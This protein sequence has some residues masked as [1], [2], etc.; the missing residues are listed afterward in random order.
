MKIVNYYKI[1]FFT[2][3]SCIDYIVGKSY[4]LALPYIVKSYI[5][6]NPRYLYETSSHVAYF[7]QIVKHHFRICWSLVSCCITIEI[8]QTGICKYEVTDLRAKSDLRDRMKNLVVVPKLS[9]KALQ[10]STLEII[11]FKSFLFILT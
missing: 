9:S 5:L 3:T 6:H 7:R 10:I 11:F 1:T 2:H 4:R 8:R